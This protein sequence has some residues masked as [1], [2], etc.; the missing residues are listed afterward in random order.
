[1]PTASPDGCYFVSTA[2]RGLRGAN[3]GEQENDRAFYVYNTATLNFIHDHL[4][5]LAIFGC[6]RLETLDNLPAGR[7]LYFEMVDFCSRNKRSYCGSRRVL[8]GG[9]GL[10]AAGLPLRLVS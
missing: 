7:Y 6:L 2:N 4:A 10:Y 5:G 8:A 3:R 1:M 9:R